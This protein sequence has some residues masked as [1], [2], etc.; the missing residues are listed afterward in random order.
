LIF[1]GL[2]GRSSMASVAAGCAFS[3]GILS[4][5]NG[6]P[7]GGGG[8]SAS[9]LPPSATPAALV[10]ELDAA[11]ALGS[12]SAIVAAVTDALA[13]SLRCGLGHALPRSYF[14]QREGASYARRLVHLD[15]KGRYS[16][17]CMC[18]AIGQR[19]PIHN[20]GNTWC[21]EGVVQGRVGFTRFEVEATED[22]RRFALSVVKHAITE[23]GYVESETAMDFHALFNSH[24]TTSVTLH[25]Y[26][27]EIFE[28]TILVPVEGASVDDKAFYA[29][30]ETKK[31]G[32]D[33]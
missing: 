31:L 11:V 32:Y 19:T 18:W 16:V 9:T 8:A 20:H 3:N 12:P 2:G 13:K 25:V 6:I 27:S 33:A 30:A 10:R 1:T 22:P 15:P 26:G 29:I 23:V 7:L 21:A 24:D 4:P 14:V 28:A 5:E 17:V